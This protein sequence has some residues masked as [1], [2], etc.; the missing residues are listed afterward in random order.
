VEILYGIGERGKGQEKERASVT[1]SNTTCV[2]VEETR[3][4]LER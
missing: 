1:S 2:K 4:Y 3:M